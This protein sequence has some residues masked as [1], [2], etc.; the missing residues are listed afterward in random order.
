MHGP[1]PEPGGATC[2][3][4]SAA[5]SCLSDDTQAAFALWHA[6]TPELQEVVLSLHEETEAINAR[7]VGIVEGAIASR[8]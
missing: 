1:L 5:D 3:S 8:G 4:M 6:L 2:T 7:I